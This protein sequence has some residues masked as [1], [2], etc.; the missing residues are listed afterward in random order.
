MAKKPAEKVEFTYQGTDRSGK[1][2]K[3]EV[4][5]LNDTLAKTEIRKLGIN[6]L[7]VKKKPQPLL[8]A[9]QKLKQKISLFSAVRLQ[10]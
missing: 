1:K 10:R 4:Y 9:V 5:A 6:P 8:V 3:G 7:R 2:V